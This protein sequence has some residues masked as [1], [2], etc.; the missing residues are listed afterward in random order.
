MNICL[1]ANVAP[2][3]SARQRD[4]VESQLSRSQ[5]CRL[6]RHWHPPKPQIVLDARIVR[7][8]QKTT[9]VSCCRMINIPIEFTHSRRRWTDCK[10]SSPSSGSAWNVC[11]WRISD[12]MRSIDNHISGR[13]R[14]A[15]HLVSLH[16]PFQQ[17][18]SVWIASMGCKRPRQSGRYQSPF[19]MNGYMRYNER[20]L[21]LRERLD[22]L[23]HDTRHQCVPFVASMPNL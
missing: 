20:S 11:G 16:H 8:S 5:T 10:H 19:P 18:M 2:M 13:R 14:S 9:T 4:P 23:P 7:H 21:D 3:Q 22:L 1:R 12:R 15:G 6:H 17:T